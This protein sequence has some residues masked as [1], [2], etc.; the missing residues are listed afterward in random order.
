MSIGSQHTT[1]SYLDETNKPDQAFVEPTVLKQRQT[2]A[3]GK[4]TRKRGELL[5]LMHNHDNLHDVKSHLFAYETLFRAYQDAHTSLRETL[6]TEESQLRESKLYQAHEGEICAFRQDIMNWI[7]DAEQKLNIDIDVLSRLRSEARSSKSSKASSTKSALA[8]EKAE[9]AA[10]RVERD[11]MVKRQELEAKKQFLK[12]EEDRLQLD[13]KI[14]KTLARSRVYTDELEAH[15]QSQFDQDKPYLS[16]VDTV[17]SGDHNVHENDNNNTASESKDVCTIA[18]TSD[19]H[20]VLP[21]IYANTV[22]KDPVADVNIHRDTELP[23]SH[24]M[25]VQPSPLSVAQQPQPHLTTVPTVT[26]SL[27]QQKRNSLPYTSHEQTATLNAAAPAFQPTRIV[28]PHIYQSSL[29]EMVTAMTL[30]QPDVQKFSG[31]PTEYHTFIMAFDTRITAK[32]SNYSDCLYFLNQYLEG[33]AKDII[34][35]CLHMDPM[36]GYNEARRILEKEY[37]DS[38][39]ISSAYINRVTSWTCIKHDD[40]IALRKFAIFLKKCLTAMQSIS[41]LSI[42]NHLPNLQVIVAKLPAYLQNKWRDQA[43]RIKTKEGRKPQFLD[44]T[45]FIESAS[46]SANDPVFGKTA[47]WKVTST[48][49]KI[50]SKPTT[51]KKSLAVS[52]Q[53][54]VPP[55]TPV[56]KHMTDSKLR[57]LLCQ[58]SHHLDDCTKF[59]KK[60]IEERRA[61]LK[62][63]RACFGCLDLNHISKGCLSKLTC[64]KC[65]KNHPTSLHIENFQFHQQSDSRQNISSPSSSNPIDED[66][67]PVQANMSNVPNITNSTILNPIIPVRV[68]QQGKGTEFLTYAF[69]DNGS[70]GCFLS[71]D[72]MTKLNATG[73]E[74]TLK[75]RTMN[76]ETSTTCMAVNNLIVSS[77]TGENPVQLPRCFSRDYIPVDH[78]QIPRP[79][80]LSKFHHLHEATSN[81]PPYLPD[82]S[83]GLLIGNNCVKALQPHKVIPSSGKGPFAVMYLHGWTINGPL[84]LQHS[85]SGILEVTDC[86]RINVHEVKVKEVMT[87]GDILR[88]F[89]S[90]FEDLRRPDL[91]GKLGPSQEDAL[92]LKT[93]ES[94]IQKLD[95]HYV[96]PLPF[97]NPDIVL[98]SN[99]NQ[100]VKRANWQRKKMM[101]NDTYCKD[102][103]NFMDNLLQ[104]GYAKKLSPDELPSKEGKVWYLPHH[105]IYHPTKKKIRIV[106]DCSAKFNGFSLNEELMQG[107]DLTSSLLGVLNRF[108]QEYVAFVGDIEAMFHQVKVIKEHQ[109]F[110][111]FLWWSKS[112]LNNNLE[113]YAMTVHLFG[114]TSS[115]SIANFALKKTADEAE[116]HINSETANTI[117]RN[118][119]V[120]DCLKSL[121]TETEAIQMISNLKDACKLGGFKIAKFCSNS[122][123]LLNSINIKDRSHDLQSHSLDY[124]DLPS[125]RALGVFWNVKEDSFGYCVGLK[126]KP[127]TRRGI[128]SMVSSLYDPLGFIAPYIL[129]AKQILRELCTDKQLD[130]DDPI[131]DDC[132]RRWNNWMDQL[133]ALKKIKVRRCL[134]PTDFGE[135]ESSQIHV[136]A[137]ASLV[138]YGSAAYLRL[139]DVQGKIHCSFLLGK[140]RLAPLNQTTIPRLELTAATVAVR[141][142]CLLCHELDITIDKIL[143]YTDSTTVLHYLLNRRKRFPIFVSNRVQ[144]ILNYSSTDD[145]HYIDSKS[146]P[147]DYA[148]RFMDTQDLLNNVSWL[149][150]PEFLWNDESTWST[151][152]A[153]AKDLATAEDVDSSA[154]VVDCTSSVSAI[155]KLI[156]YFSDWFR[157]KH[158]VAT[159][160][161]VIQILRDRTNQHNGS[162]YC[163]SIVDLNDAEHAVLRYVQGANFQREINILTSSDSA[164]VPKSSHIYKLD[165]YMEDDLVRVGGRLSKTNLQHSV[166]HPIL[167]PKKSHVTTLIIRH[168]HSKMAHA[169]RNHV[170]AH[171]RETFWIIHANAAVRHVISK[172]VT[173]RKLRKPVAQQ[174]MADL[175]VE[176]CST[177]P[178][179]TYAGVDLFGPFKIKQGRKEHKRYG[180]LFTCLAS[181]AIHIEVA[182]S[183]DT[184]SFLNALRRFIARRGPVAQLRC[185]NG[186]NLVGAER[187]LREALNEMKKDHIYHQLLKENIQWIFNPPTASHFGGSWE[188]QIR[189]VRK[190]LSHLSHEFGDMF[191]D[192]SFCTLMCE[193]EAVVNSRPLT[194]PSSDPNDVG[195]LSPNHILNMKAGVILPPPGK[196]QRADVYLR[197]RWRRVQYVVNIFWTR[198][199][200]EYLL[201]LQNRQKWNCAHR[202]FAV[203]DL[204]IIQ[205]DS[206]PRSCWALGRVIK[207]EPDQKGFVRCVTVKTLTSTL[208]RPVSRLVLVLSHDEQQCK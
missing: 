141:L 105:G 120:D 124:Q 101:A 52:L 82:I 67:E 117:R 81:M 159:Y 77:Y 207:T 194:T 25:E 108:R 36:S 58:K 104:N 43:N 171:L 173:C 183:L 30:P 139:V 88:L 127:L 129:Y 126:L 7:R 29:H 181:R 187:E 111:R 137:D 149:N 163:I 17:I 175:P 23:H 80:I 87:T 177:E 38:Y 116:Q 76:G 204:V 193:V 155:D 185:D 182:A 136:F 39:K 123:K 93:A 10:L 48:S 196:F 165:P 121:S 46:E 169:G 147:A 201:T 34:S 99:R 178:P 97:R 86:N 92:F 66:T 144:F 146:N 33:E 208:R 89:D 164:T 100:A 200:R 45:S 109:D 161:K 63:K 61:F 170:L 42:L 148:S 14:N 12:A 176:R 189:T 128:L 24:H 64:K 55:A 26:Y 166:K 150:G 114:A 197:K 84:H 27:S 198:W 140:A 158:A 167:L 3:V 15:T 18:K 110:L 202:N 70:N 68:R 75:L 41:D 107:P 102:Y 135:I 174:K 19:V 160:R 32:T 40:A 122:S 179:F 6:I 5:K 125:E 13:L 132:I 83:I 152:P 190:V 151:T 206:L 131:P 203:G 156:E 138:G 22:V 95:G 71:N 115:P 69:F 103:I 180:V 62:G 28:S 106:F 205:D 153:F 145:W 1:D 50:S 94:E 56:S 112:N 57:C 60:T 8:R 49:T 188:R 51:S 113:E 192:E 21:H 98:P 130:W 172:C 142:G 72:L 59:W 154:T 11:M 134:K 20:N 91:P 2:T 73:H 118:F 37:G 85:E 4:L 54:S 79:E 44:L 31:D 191:D 9:L 35:G 16:A 186:T 119:Y 96:L 53:Q 184:D 47:L 195:A 157:L 162:D 133:P 143:Y 199:R 90:D 65:G 168:I 74:T 78:S